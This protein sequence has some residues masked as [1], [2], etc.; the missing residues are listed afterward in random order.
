MGLMGTAFRKRGKRDEA[1]KERKSEKGGGRVGVRREQEVHDD[2][3][4]GCKLGKRTS[5]L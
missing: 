1:L 4:R 3:R 5:D 2:I